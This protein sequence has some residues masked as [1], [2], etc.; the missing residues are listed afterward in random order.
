M[1]FFLVLIF[2]TLLFIIKYPILT[3]FM[4]EGFEEFDLDVGGATI[5]GIKGGSGPPL[6]LLHGYPQTHIIWYKIAP[7]L[8]ESF[9]VVASDLRGYGDS[10][11]PDGGDGHENYAF[12]KMASD[13]LA[14]M[15]SFGYETFQLA[16]HDRGARTA[17][18]LALDH[19]S[20]VAN[21]ILMDIV[22]T[23]TLYETA[24]QRMATGYYHWYFLIQPTDFPERL[25]GAD[26][27]FF[28]RKTLEHWSAKKHSPT[29]P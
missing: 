8:A 21:L 3:Q 9:T 25:I 17:H 11:K 19:P 10:S 20:A 7:Q 22:P 15:R 27:E 23:L 18:R 29:M 1:L 4:F 13:Q 24:D 28:L 26:P 12:R 2:S 14:V 16:G 6:L 5:H